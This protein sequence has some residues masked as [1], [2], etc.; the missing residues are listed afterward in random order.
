MVSKRTMSVL[1]LLAIAALLLAACGSKP[2]EPGDTAE[3]EGFFVA[4]PR[5]TIEVGA[6]GAAESVIGIPKEILS[7]LMGGNGLQ[8]MDAN[9]VANM[10][11]NNIQHLELVSGK[12]GLFLFVNGQALPYL[13]WEGDKLRDSLPVI[14]QLN[15]LYGQLTGQQLAEWIPNML[16]LLQRVGMDVVIKLPVKE[17][18]TPIEVRAEDAAMPE[19][20]PITDTASAGESAIVYLPIFYDSSGT[21]QLMGRAVS[22]GASTHRCSLRWAGNLPLFLSQDTLNSLVAR[23][24]NR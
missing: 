11:A 1:A 2:V 18:A 24:S 12:D 20:A 4:L 23:T 10:Q 21:P 19:P 5:A 17:G 14:R 15:T 9:M 3:S 22:S 13:R 6:N 8:I 7:G 16:P